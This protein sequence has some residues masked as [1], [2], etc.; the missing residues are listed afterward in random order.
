MSL[1]R[2][3]AVVHP[4]TSMS[5]RTERNAYLAI[6]CT[7][8]TIL[9][10]C[11]PAL[12]T[13]GE[14]NYNGENSICAFL[15]AQYNQALYQVCFFL[16]SF[17]IPITLILIL[18]LLMLKRLWFGVVPGGHMSAES[19]RSKKRVTRMVVVVVAIFTFCWFPIQIVLVLKSFD[20][21]EIDTFRLIVQIG[22][23]ILGWPLKIK[24][25]RNGLLMSSLS[26]L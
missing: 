6:V 14:F 22:S 23:H 26:S 20:A 13:H 3:L 16:S 18:Y 21:Y 12:V 4:I 15:M 7:W 2:F 25:Q 1:D 19:L 17:V 24:C 10:A 9:I 8:V 5:I 11:V